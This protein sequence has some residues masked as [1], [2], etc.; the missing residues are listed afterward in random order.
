MKERL[1]LQLGRQCPEHCSLPPREEPLGDLR[2]GQIGTD[3]LEVDAYLPAARDRVKG[4]ALGVGHA[5]ADGIVPGF[6]GKGRLSM[7]A[8]TKGEALRRPIQGAA[9]NVPEHSASDDKMLAVSVEII[10]L[11]SRPFVRSKVVEEALNL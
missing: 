1:T 9:E 6:S 11:G 3:V 2:N 8:I 5:E 4:D 7:R 10:P